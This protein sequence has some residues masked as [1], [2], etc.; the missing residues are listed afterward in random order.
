MNQTDQQKYNL[1]EK[2]DEQKRGSRYIKIEFFSDGNRYFFS[3]HTWVG[4]RGI[5]HGIKNAYTSLAAA[6]KGAF[7]CL[8]ENHDPQLL[9]QFSFC[10][11]FFKA[12]AIFQ[13]CM[14]VA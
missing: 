3:V 10:K 13:S 1:V 14:E 7:Q 9:R 2:I 6:K 11:R 4:N 8:V 5:G 12:A